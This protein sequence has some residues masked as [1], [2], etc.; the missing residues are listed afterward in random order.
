MLLLSYNFC[1]YSFTIAFN[2]SVTLISLQNMGIIYFSRWSFSSITFNTSTLL[3]NKSENTFNIISKLSEEFSISFAYTV[4]KLRNKI[5]NPKIQS[6]LNYIRILSFFIEYNFTFSF[7]K[8]NKQ[9]DVK[10]FLMKFIR[11]KIAAN[12]A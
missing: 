11:A 1:N 5:L 4:F 7:Y 9:V 10:I 2:A 6:L 12:C 3:V 8:H